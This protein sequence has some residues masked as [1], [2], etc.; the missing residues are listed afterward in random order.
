MGLE[1]LLRLASDFYREM[2]KTHIRPMFPEDMQGASRHL[3]LFL[4]QVTG[5][6]PLFNELRGPPRMRMRHIPFEI[7]EAARQA[8]LQTFLKVFG[9]GAAYGFPAEHRGDFLKF[10]EEFSAWM[11][12]KA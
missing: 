10:L 1:N 6:P 8:W 4:A 9:D 11:V 5:G 3:A 12:N 7:D 2:E